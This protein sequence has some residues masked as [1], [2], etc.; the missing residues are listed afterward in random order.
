MSEKDQFLLLLRTHLK[1]ARSRAIKLVSGSRLMTLTL[2]LFLATYS[3]TAY[4]MF[5]RG[6]IYFGQL[7]AAGNLLVDRMIHIVFFCFLMM[8]MFSV[9]VSG[10]IALYR[11]RD[12]R[13][14]LTLPISHR[15][16]FLWKVFE[17]GAFSSW[18]LLLIATPLLVAFAEFR[19][20]GPGF[21]LRTAIALPPFLIIAISG[22]GLALLGSV[23]WMKRK[24]MIAFGTACLLLFSGWLTW[25]VLNEKKITERVGFSAALT[26]QQV[27]K[28]TDLSA[29]R[30][31]PSTWY[32]EALLA[33]SRP[34][35]IQ[36]PPMMPALL[37]SWS[38]MG[39]LAAGWLGRRWFYESWNHSV[40]NAAIAA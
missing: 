31:I 19:D 28:H 32:T 25:T 35:R 22:A 11:S 30:L 18:G 39:A 17:A 40:Q 27:M 23:R 20:A 37:L 24:Q 38:L 10:Y 15:V 5:R 36:K 16:L 3:I 26:F 29:S 1:M 7:P 13:W 8:L 21:Y 14:L 2:V 12:T 33:W 34:Q 4:L 9:A 6:L